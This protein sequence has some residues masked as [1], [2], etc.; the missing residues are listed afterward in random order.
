MEKPPF[1]STTQTNGE[2]ETFDENDPRLQDIPA[3]VRRIVSLHD[4]PELPCLTF[5][6]FLLTIVFVIPGAFLSVMMHFRTT[7]EPYSVFSFRLLPATLACGSPKSFPLGKSG[8][9]SPGFSFNLNPGP[10]SVKEHVLVTISAASGPL[11]MAELH[12][13]SRIHPA[14]AIFFMWGIVWTG[15]FFAPLA[16][17]FPICD[18]QFP[19]FMALCQ[20]ALFETQKKQRE[21]PTAESRKQAK[22]FLWALLGMT[23]WQFIPEFGS[24]MLGSLASLCW[25]AP[26][27]SV[28]DFVGAG[29]DRMG[30]LN[31][32]LDWSTISATGSLFLTSYVWILNPAAK[33]GNLG[34]WHRHLMSNRLFLENGTSYPITKLLTPNVSFNETAYQEFGPPFVGTHT[35]FFNYVAYTSAIIWAALFGYKVVRASLQKMMQQTKS[36]AQI[37]SQYSDQLSILQR[38]YNE[39]PLWWFLALF[40]ASLISFGTIIATGNM[41]IPVWTYFV[42]IAT[43]A[44][45][46]V[47]LGWLY[48]L[49]NF[50][51]SIGAAN[52]LLCG[53]MANSVSGSKNP[54]GASVYCAIAGNA[55]YRAQLNLQ[56]MK[57]GHY[58]HMSP[59]TVFFSQVF[60]SFLGVTV[61]YAVVRW[62]LD[63]KLDYL[64]GVKKDPAH[65]WTAQSLAL[66]LTLGVQYVLI[67]PLR[68]FE[69]HIHKVLPYG[70]GSLVGAFVPIL[71]YGMHRLFPRAKFQLWNS[72]IFFSPMANFYGNISTGYLSSFLGGS[73]VMFWAYRYR[74]DMWARWNYILAAAFDA[75]FNFNMLLTFLLFGAGEFMT[76]PYWWGNEATSSERCFAL[77]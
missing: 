55:R 8:S 34:E 31:L 35:I 66:Y 10:F 70:H 67:G 60:G 47:P 75:G 49:S 69:Q 4:D 9:L 50:L 74:Y 38:A 64:T 28:A 53:L 56:D 42:A 54:T 5:R 65:Q 77:E 43:G 61:N 76:M 12:F 18:P 14:A 23:L 57:I 16:R 21:T 20:T 40:A 19:W 24:P 39:V 45:L 1:V 6:Y 3:Y 68:L 33:Y 59:K 27:N 29:F 51:P 62:A 71:I 41:F 36:G 13:D 22:V 30:V 15:Y 32:S 2:E 37:S 17:Q 48:A 11:A 72:T 58:M 7:Y 63:T 44:F 73:V 46:V 25:V 52:E 26:S